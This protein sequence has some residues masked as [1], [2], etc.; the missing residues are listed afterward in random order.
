MIDVEF[1]GTRVRPI[2]FPPHL[3]PFQVFDARAKLGGGL[4][5]GRAL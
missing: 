2:P 4:V 3:L 5:L 1:C